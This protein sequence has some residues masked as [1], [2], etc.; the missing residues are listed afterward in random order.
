LAVINNL[1]ALY[2]SEGNYA[3][4][5]PVFTHALEVQRRVLGEAHPNTLNTLNNLALLYLNQHKYSHAGALLRP[6]L[7]GLE[8]T[9]PDSWTRYDCQSMLGA[10]LAGE[11]KYAEAEP[12]LLTGYEGM[13]AREASMPASSRFKLKESGR[14]IVQLY[15]DWGQAGAGCQVARESQGGHSRYGSE[16]LNFLSLR[17]VRGAARQILNIK[18]CGDSHTATRS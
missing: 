17:T 14:W 5:E 3:H 4:A 1:A 6:A 18:F 7:N 9:T 10:S 2:R 13:L 12:L 11:K 16:A 8:T 15:Q